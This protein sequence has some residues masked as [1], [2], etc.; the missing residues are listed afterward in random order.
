MAQ[1]DSIITRR[2]AK[3]KA[4]NAAGACEAL[5]IGR[6]MLHSLIGGGHLPGAKKLGTSRRAPWLIPVA[7]VD[8]FLRSEAPERTI[9]VEC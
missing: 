1:S 3:P 8:K 4:Y 9:A 7:S 6:D 5:G 2:R